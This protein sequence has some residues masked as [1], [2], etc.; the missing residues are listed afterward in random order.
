MVFRAADL[1]GK[2][3]VVCGEMAGS[4]FYLPLLIG[5]GAREFSMN[6]DSLGAIR[7]VIGRISFDECR[8]LARKASVLETADAIEAYMND[9][10]RRNWPHV[11]PGGISSST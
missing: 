1:Q 2:S 10:Y 7:Q 6:P 8:E 4:P 3:T 5:L 11:F 9:F